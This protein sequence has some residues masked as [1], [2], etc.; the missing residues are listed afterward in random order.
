MKPFSE[1]LNAESKVLFC[2]YYTNQF[3][4]Q[5]AQSKINSRNIVK[6]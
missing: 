1:K 4:P 5:L 6:I 3:L 2:L